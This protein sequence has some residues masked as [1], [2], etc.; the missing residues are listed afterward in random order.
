MKREEILSRLEYEVP[1]SKKKRVIIDTDVCNEADDHFSIMQHLLTP[2]EEIL[3]IIAAHNE[4]HAKNIKD[5]IDRGD[6]IPDFM[7]QMAEARGKTM[8]TSYQEGLKIL[9]LA[10]IDDVPMLRGSA[11]ELSSL[12]V[13]KLPQ[14]EGVDFIIKEALKDDDRPIY[15][16]LLGAIT[17][18]AIAYLKEPKIAE[19]VIAV[20]VGGGAY[21]HGEMEFNLLQ[22]VMAANV[23]MSSPIPVWQ[24]TKEG[25]KTIEFT[26][27]E[28]VD[29]IKPCG[30]IGAYL[31]KQM[32]DFNT[33]MGSMGPGMV[34]PHGETWC[35]GDNSTNGVL[36][37]CQEKVVY[38]EYKAPKI[39]DDLSYSEGDTDKMVRVYS[40]IDSRMVMSDLYSKLRL[41]YKK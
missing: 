30:E 16:C 1:T 22:D 10:D 6:N 8:E 34:W 33:R 4:Y 14:S 9:K 19:K 38:K 39:N 18:L 20:W 13:D 36:L 27:A 25:Y 29:N 41:C 37:H 5:S 28:L 11:Y 32:L 15:V 26:L 24:I 31:C 35:L 40:Q 2:S 3:G 7:K 23:I 12:D 17:D 21:P